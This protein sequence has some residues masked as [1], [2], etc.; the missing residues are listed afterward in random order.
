MP[1]PNCWKTTTTEFD[2]SPGLQRIPSTRDGNVAGTKYTV[3]PISGFDSD[4]VYSNG[5]FVTYSEG[6]QH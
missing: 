1:I 6:A 5:G 4:I 2:C 3:G